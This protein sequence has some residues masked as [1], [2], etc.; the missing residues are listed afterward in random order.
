MIAYYSAGNKYFE[1]KRYEKKNFTQLECCVSRLNTLKKK[2]KNL[3]KKKR[4]IVSGR[5]KLIF[6]GAD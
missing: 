2:L 1:L 3:N 4:E 5:R 6:C